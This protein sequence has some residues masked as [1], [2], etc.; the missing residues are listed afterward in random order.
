MRD[1]SKFRT[2]SDREKAIVAVAVLLDGR[3][4]VDYLSSDKERH[5]ALCR[6]AKDLAEIPADLRMPLLGSMLR[7]VL[8]DL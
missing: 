3:D 2:L 1:L 8:D 5:I 6:A 7:K 4:A